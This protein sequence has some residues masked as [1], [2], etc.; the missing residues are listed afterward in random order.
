MN[1]HAAAHQKKNNSRVRVRKVS[2]QWIMKNQKVMIMIK[3]KMNKKKRM[4]SKSLL[5]I[6]FR[7]SI[8]KERNVRE[9]LMHLKG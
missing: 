8:F 2:K 5:S 4:M 6:R 7:G 3:K 9:S 1:L